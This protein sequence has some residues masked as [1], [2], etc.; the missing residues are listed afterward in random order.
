MKHDVQA[1]AYAQATPTTPVESDSEREAREKYE[2][3]MLNIGFS[4]RRG[5]PGVV[6]DQ[7]GLKI[8]R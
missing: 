3:R 8:N 1:E 6:R 5:F 4:N 2:D 7:P